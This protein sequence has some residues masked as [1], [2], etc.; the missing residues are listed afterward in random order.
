MKVFAVIN[1]KGGTGKTTVTINLAAQLAALGRRALVADMDP[2]GN[3]TSG[4]GVP[5]RR[6][7]RGMYEALQGEDVTRCAVGSVSGR[8]DILGARAELAGAEVELPSSP[9]WQAR[10][11]ETLAPALSQYDFVLIDCPPSLGALTVNALTAADGA[12][13]P[14]QCEYFALEGLSDLRRTI[15]ALRR[16]WNPNLKIAGIVRPMLDS[17]NKLERDISAELDRHF[18]G[19]VFGAAVRRNVRVAEAPSYGM[20]VLSYAP[21]SSGAD[22]YRRLGDEFLERFAQP[23]EQA[24]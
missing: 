10:L 12:L 1:Q 22:G 16:K 24:R 11:R 9:G 21:S 7:S 5:R 6:L 15:V 3:A 13:V 19:I 14:M 2:Q 17:R 4:S 23:A 8:H 20:P 18:A